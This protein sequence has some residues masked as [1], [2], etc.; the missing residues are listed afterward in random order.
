M[1]VTYYQRNT[2]LATGIHFSQLE[3]AL[4]AA[5]D[6]VAI[7][8]ASI[9][10]AGEIGYV[11]TTASGAPNLAQW[12]G[13]TYRAQFDVNAI[14]ANVTFGLLPQEGFAGH[15]A[16]VDAGLTADLETVEQAEAAFAGT[17]LK[18]ATA[19]WTPASGSTADRLEL[20][21][22]AGNTATMAQD[23]NLN[24]SH[25]D[26]FVQLPDAAPQPL[27]PLLLRRVRDLP[28]ARM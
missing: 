19:S 14:G 25:A 1:P 26:A 5:F 28:H 17:G 8:G 13:G 22:A 6:T 11:F 7:M 15:L 4:D 16:R 12:P 9:D 2:S 21:V 24:V 20:C 18:L 3:R 10:A 23:L 27:P